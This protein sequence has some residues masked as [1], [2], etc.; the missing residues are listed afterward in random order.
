GGDAQKV[1]RTALERGEHLQEIIDDLVRLSRGAENDRTA[2][3][4]RRL[5]DEVRSRADVTV[6]C[7]DGLPEVRVSYAAV[8]QIV[9]VL[10]DNAATHGK[11]PITVSAVD[12]GTGL[13]IEVAD[14]GPGIPDGLDVFRAPADGH[15]I[16]LALARSLAEAEGGRLVVRSPSPPVFSLLLP[17]GNYRAD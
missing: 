6:E 10:V 13:A 16:G 7:E 5:L 15:G 1:I 3:D 2:L 4:V 8:R 11:P 12:V 17:S 14:A 9:H